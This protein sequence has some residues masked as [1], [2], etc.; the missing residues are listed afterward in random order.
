M[1]RRRRRVLTRFRGLL[2]VSPA[3]LLLTVIFVVPL[4]VSV[5]M[6]LSS[7][8]LLGAHHFTGVGNY[9]RLFKDPQIRQALVF[10]LEFAVVITPVVFF[11]GLVLALLVQHERRGIGVVRTAI[12]A[13]VA[14]GFASASYLWL[15]LTD[16]STGLFDRLLVDL[17]L[18]KEP[19]NWL[20]RPSLALLLVAIVTVWKIAGF[21]MIA[22]MNG[23]QSVPAEVEE[24]AT[25]DGVGRFRMLWGIKLPL[26]R[27]SV[28]FTLTFVAIGSFLTF[29]QFYILTGG[30]PDN[31]TITAVYRIYN[32]AFTQSDLGYAAAVSMVFLVLL[33]VITS[34]QLFLLRRGADT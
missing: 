30:G 19:V 5:Y 10:T 11:G 34:T 25:V 17:H 6:S 18:T 33:L 22:L 26:M 29:D 7:W 20:L 27:D 13:P 4:A 9:S 8:P 16:P 28:A 1:T 24:A 2:L 3:L 32:V 12:F 15:A 21:A 14:V 23:L 31:K